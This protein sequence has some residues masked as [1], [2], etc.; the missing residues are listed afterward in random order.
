M[1]AS[2][3]MIC[4]LGL[5]WQASQ[6]LAEAGSLFGGAGNTAVHAPLMATSV[7]QGAV[8][9][10]SL[11]AVSP[12]GTTMQGASLFAGPATSG[13]FAPMPKRERNSPSQPVPRYGPMT[14]YA[15]RIRHMIA[16]AEAGKKGYD[17]VQYGA[18]IRPAKAPTQMSVQ[19]IYDW[20]DATPRQPHA[21]GRYQ[22]IPPT[23]RRLMKRLGASPSERFSP[24]LQD[25][26]ADLL[27][28]DAGLGRYQRGEITRVSLMNNLAKIWAGLPN[29]SGKS[30]YHGYAGNKATMSWGE[31][32]RM[33]D[34]IL[35]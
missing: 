33:M 2:R 18:T 6:T 8:Q 19:E 3:V 25:R 17:A 21:I 27:L 35:G 11:E 10:A 22:F 4:V 31:Y 34:Q 9:D 5:F 12:R 20:I 14:T 16:R 23:L 32:K 28:A 24:Q 7:P 13:F 29:S 26:L 30:H 15:D 1:W